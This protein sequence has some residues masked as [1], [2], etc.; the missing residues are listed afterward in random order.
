VNGVALD[1]DVTARVLGAPQVGG[2]NNDPV[3]TNVEI[4]KEASP[5]ALGPQRVAVILLKEKSVDPYDPYYSKEQTE[6][7]IFRGDVQKFFKEASYG[8]MSLDKEKS[9]VYGWYEFENLN[10][11]IIASE[12]AHEFIQQVI[13]LTDSDINYADFDRIMIGISLRNVYK[14]SL[15]GETIVDIDTSVGWGYVGKSTYFINN[16]EMLLTFSD[17][18]IGKSLSYIFA[19]ELGHNLGV[20]HANKLDCTEYSVKRYKDDLYTR[21]IDGCV[22]IEYGNFFDTM[23]IANLGHFNGYFKEVFNWIN[24][25]NKSIVNINKPG[26]YTVK[27]QPLEI[28]SVVI[29][30]IARENTINF[31][32]FYIEY[33]TRSPFGSDEDDSGILINK[34]YES[35]TSWLLDAAPSFD[36]P[37][38]F[39]PQGKTFTDEKS[40]VKITAVGKDTVDV[41]IEKPECKSYGF[42]TEIDGVY[43][44]PFIIYNDDYSFG[45][46]Q[47]DLT[48]QDYQCTLKRNKQEPLLFVFALKIKNNNSYACPDVRIRASIDQSPWEKDPKLAIDERSIPSSEYYQYFEPSVII[49][50]TT[51]AGSY[52]IGVKVENVD[53]NSKIFINGRI[54]Q[55]VD[56][57]QTLEGDLNNDNKVDIFDL[58]TVAKDFG[59]KGE[60]FPGDADKNSVVDIFDL[61]I[62]AKNFGK[63]L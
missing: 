46:D 10:S 48:C 42:N 58:V 16:N 2:E 39:L 54:L 15:T 40:G 53:A 23:G 27:L 61:V 41:Q 20:H 45:F 30:K 12:H 8:K 19:H 14:S 9:K 26:A 6:E 1:D 34:I 47:A 62:V 21:F 28:D 44:Y 56:D 63:K 35:S 17:F 7:M 38:Y 18:G 36:Y 52:N 33:R 22:H 3:V 59:K 31:R 24:S 55:I 37:A 29:A 49:P 4:L 11:P 50:A 32:P 60:G 25:S 13:A 43:A 51:P 57:F 5:D